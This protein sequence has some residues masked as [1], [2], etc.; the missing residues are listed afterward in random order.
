M[1]KQIWTT[2]EGKEIAIEDMKDSH[3]INTI[4]LLKKRIDEWHQIS[5]GAYPNFQGEMAQ[6][7]A[8]KD[9]ERSEE[10]AFA[11]GGIRQIMIE[12]AKKRKLKYGKE[13]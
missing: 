12:E 2:R 8:E 10:R 4:R 11:M 13:A 3:L 6:E 9:Y 7:C 1:S 5:S